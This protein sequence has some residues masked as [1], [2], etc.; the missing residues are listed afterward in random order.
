MYKSLLCLLVALLVQMASARFYKPLPLVCSVTQDVQYKVEE[1]QA[2]EIEVV[3][4]PVPIS[5]MQ[6]NTVYTTSVL[7]VTAISV[8]TNTAQPV[9]LEVTDIQ[10]EEVTEPLTLVKVNTVTSRV[11]LTQL[12]VLTSTATN[13][14]TDIHTL[15]AVEVVPLTVTDVETVLSQLTE[16]VAGT[17]LTTLTLTQGQL[18]TTVK[19]LDVPSTT[20][21]GTATVTE[22][23]TVTNTHNLTKMITQTICPPPNEI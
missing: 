6:L 10:V 19:V 13:Y 5:K 3:R 12:D 22:V 23:N 1:L 21:V 18:R 4:V 15:T 16:T 11:V 17:V 7:P 20:V 14:H 9:R 2:K 8:Q